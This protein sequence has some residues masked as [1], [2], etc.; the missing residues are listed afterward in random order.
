MLII[1]KKCRETEEEV[2]PFSLSITTEIGRESGRIPKRK[3]LTC[4]VVEGLWAIC[5][6][7]RLA[8]VQVKK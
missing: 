1:F 5:F 4:V 8:T 3:E 2:Q 6:V 7:S